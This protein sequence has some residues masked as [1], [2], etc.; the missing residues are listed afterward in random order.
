MSTPAA[1]PADADDPG[2]AIAAARKARGL[3]QSELA[4]QAAISPSLLRK[5][6]RGARSL[7]PGVRAAL[8]TVLVTV[9]PAE[10]G[11]AAPERIAA[12]LPQLRE[13]MDAYD[14][15]PDLPYAIRPIT[16]LRRMTSSATAWRLSS[17]YAKLAGLLPGLITDL[18]A[19]AL[20]TAGHEQE[21][22]FA[23]LALAYRAADAIADKHGQHDMSGRATELI[24]WAAARSADPQLEMM[25]AY[26]RAELFFSGQHARTGLRMIDSA[27]APAH[28]ADDV[29]LL[30]MRGALC[31]RAA[32]LAARAGMPD[33]AAD[34]IAQAQAI[35]RQVPD[36]VY[37]GTAFGPASVRVHELALAVEAGDVARAV[38]LAGQWQPPRALP[39]ERRSHFHIEAARA[40]SWAG[41]RD[42]AVTALWE[43]RRAAPQHTRCNPAVIETVG[44]LIRG[45]RKPPPPL[46]QLATWIGHQ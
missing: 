36:G 21:Q 28:G 5:I 40:Y 19:T 23:V 46:I 24:R 16:E 42:Q 10:D 25:S 27:T 43:A 7:T 32:V 1:G 31:M 6:E 15:P 35:A 22:A 11:A 44:V 38:K 18:T 33:E 4:R 29:P 8:D 3:T 20:N 13:V 14:I 9:P 39:A 17:Q 30:A 45:S 41:N 12:A 37:H 2:Q 34:R 26:V